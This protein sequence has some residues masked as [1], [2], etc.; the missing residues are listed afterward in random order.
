MNTV[1]ESPAKKVILKFEYGETNPS[2]GCSVIRMELRSRVFKVALVA[3][4]GLVAIAG[5]Q[6]D[7][8]ASSTDPALCTS[9]A[10]ECEYAPA[11]APSLD[12]TVCYQPGMAL[13]LEDNGSCDPGY[14]SYWVSAGEVLDPNTGEVTAYIR[15]KN[16][17]DL[18]YCVPD[19]P[20]DPPGEEGAMCCDPQ[21]GNCTETDAIC[22]PSEIAV[23]C[24]DGQTPQQG[25]PGLWECQED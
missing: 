16:A 22:P 7:T 17:C 5:S 13:V 24:P 12:A 11:S 18:G 6:S 20:D 2:N 21:T 8:E 23:W 15:L 4:A 1:L 25:Q 10:S 9:I 14:T 3:V 19:D